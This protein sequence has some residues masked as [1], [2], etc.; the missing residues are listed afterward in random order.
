[1]RK[2]RNLHQWFADSKPNRFLIAVIQSKVGGRF[3]HPVETALLD[4]NNSK[5]IKE[6]V[7]T[8]Y[9]RIDVQIG[10]REVKFMH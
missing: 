7:K 3:G 5:A 10:G 1:M 9:I 8:F 4:L 6:R 2:T